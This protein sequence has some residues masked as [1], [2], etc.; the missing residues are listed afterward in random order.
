[1]IVVPGPS[2]Q[3]LSCRVGR[4]GNFEVVDME[5]SRFP[6]GESYLRVCE[7]VE[8]KDVAIVQ[9][10]RFDHEFVSLLQLID[11]CESA[12]RI[13]VVIPYMGY[14]RQDRQFKAGEP[15]S[16]RAIAR[17][18][19]A[20]EV[21]LIN[22]HSELVM[23]YFVCDVTNLD[24]SRLLGEYFSRMDLSD[25]LFV[26]PDEGAIS[27]AEEAATILHTDYSYFRKKRISPEEVITSGDMD[28]KGRD[29]VLI[30]DIISTGGT[31][32][33]AIQ[34]LRGGGARSVYVS[35]IHPVFVRNAIL[36]LYRAGAEEIVFTDTIENSQ[37][38]VSVAP[39][40]AR[41]L[42]L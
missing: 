36:R 4:E 7:E 23:D 19:E 17:S 13:I 12:H 26:A 9:S 41:H 31:M 28:V 27:L 30:D 1:M 32:V 34:K 2:S 10:T 18:I 16:S 25:P 24:A 21:V 5:Y 42:R 11:A 39:I 22:V 38:K 40:I 15:I 35:C 14:A 29:V 8:N 6:D 37:Y 33:E 3:S 20:D